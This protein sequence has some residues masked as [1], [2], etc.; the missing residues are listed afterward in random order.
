MEDNLIAFGSEV[1]AL[2]DGK[3]GGYLIRFTKH[4]ATDLEGDYFDAD[5]DIH[6]PTELPLLYNHGMDGTIKKRVI[7]T[8][9]TVIKDAGL[10]AESQL[11]MRDE[12]E[13]AIYEMA[14]A[15]K[16]GYSSGALS[17]LVE[18]EPVGK[19]FHIKTWFVGEAS[20]TP[21]PADFNNKVVTLKSLIPA[22]AAL[23]DNADNIKWRKRSW[24]R[25]KSKR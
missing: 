17:H 11:N 4:T 7:G 10:W 6:T 22:D 20:L 16:L 2:P 24:M 21:T 9:I 15:G 18:R 23:P 14:K 19:S 25:T 8:A 3:I 13:K 12:Y 5:T 1:K